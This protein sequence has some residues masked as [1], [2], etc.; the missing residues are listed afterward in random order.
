MLME[1]L[2]LSLAGWCGPDGGFKGLPPVSGSEDLPPE[3]GGEH[4][5]LAR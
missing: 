5:P 1:P 4:L 2:S 3:G